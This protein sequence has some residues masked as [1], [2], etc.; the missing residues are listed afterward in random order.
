[1]RPVSRVTVLLPNLNCLMTG[2]TVSSLSLFTVFALRETLGTAGVRT[3]PCPNGAGL[4]AQTQAAGQA[5]VTAQIPS[6]QVVQ[7]LSALVNQSGSTAE[8]GV[9]LLFVL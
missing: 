4:A 5:S 7:Q 6:F 9:I 8:G 1:M 3:R 2:F